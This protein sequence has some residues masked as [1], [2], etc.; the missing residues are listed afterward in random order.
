MKNKNIELHNQRAH[1]RTLMTEPWL[2]VLYKVLIAM[3]HQIGSTWNVSLPYV[4]WCTVII[5][6]RTFNF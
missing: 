3:S 5:F 1:S 2:H 6:Y 4:I